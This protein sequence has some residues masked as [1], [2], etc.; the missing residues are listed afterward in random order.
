M[1]GSRS[2]GVPADIATGADLTTHTGAADP[3]GDRAYTDTA[4]STHT[5][6]TTA[7]HG[8]ADTTALAL[9]GHAHAGADITSGTVA[10]A[11]LPIGTTAS[12]VAAGDHTHSPANWTAVDQGLL[13]WSMDPAYMAGGSTPQSGSGVL[14]LARMHLA[15]ASTVTNVI[16]HVLTAGTGLTS[17]QCFAGL[18]T[19]AG[20]KIDVTADQSTAW[21]ST[22]NK[23]M[24]LAAGT[25]AAAAGDYYVGWWS[26]TGTTN[27]AFLRQ[28]ATT[29]TIGGQN[30]P[31]YRF[32]TANTGL[33]DAASAPSTLGTQ[34]G[35]IVGWFAAL[36]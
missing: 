17:G 4:L 1:T 3:H 33:T 13:A 29:A 32:G 11:R 8:I 16:L 36:S 9:T 12:T 21:A 14:Q 2:F 26:N 22:G 7:V 27:P 35:V 28:G 23:I 10:Y 31:N 15:T 30:G 5:A 24:P 19:A 20:A 25:Y 6:D 18:W 34:S